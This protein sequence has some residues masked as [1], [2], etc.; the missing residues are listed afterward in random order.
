MKNNNFK[1][2]FQS[3]SEGILGYQVFISKCNM[4]E[5]Y[6][7]YFFYSPILRMLNHRGLIAKCEVSIEKETKAKGDY[8]R[9]DFVLFKEVPIIEKQDT[10]EKIPNIALE[11][12]YLHNIGRTLDIDNDASKMCFYDKK[13]DI[14]KLIL[15]IYSKHNK[16][17]KLKLKKIPEYKVTNYVDEVTLKCINKIYCAAIF[18]VNKNQ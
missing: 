14:L 7:E 5:A 15:V 2:I 13:N 12:K 1:K 6:S 9:I 3:L 17:D 16:D 18:Q 4:L 10:T 8:K 11:V